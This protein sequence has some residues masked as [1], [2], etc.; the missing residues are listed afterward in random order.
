MHTRKPNSSC[1]RNRKN[2]GHA[3]VAAKSLC[4]LLLI[5]VTFMPDSASSNGASFIDIQRLDNAPD[6]YSGVY[7]FPLLFKPVTQNAKVTLVGFG[8]FSVRHRAA[9]TDGHQIMDETIQFDGGLTSKSIEYQIAEDSSCQTG[10][11][12]FINSKST[13]PDGCMP[14]AN[15]AELLILITP[16]IE[17][18]PQSNEVLPVPPPF[19]TVSVST[20]LIDTMSDNVVDTE[21]HD[22][23]KWFNAEKGFGFISPD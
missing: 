8:T 17:R 3:C 14:A 10:Y 1:S 6:N 7:L 21:T 23:V 4:M 22:T 15:K 5:I 2:L 11:A 9:S 20:Q 19:S 16:R 13:A 12:V 18:P